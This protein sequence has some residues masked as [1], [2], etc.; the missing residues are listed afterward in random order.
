MNR[1]APALAIAVL[2]FLAFAVQAEEVTF[3]DGM[4]VR[5]RFT[6]YPLAEPL[7]AEA[8]LSQAVAGTTIPLWSASVDSLGKTFKYTMV[9]Q[10]PQIKLKNPATTIPLVIVP[11]KFVFANGDTFD[12]SAPDPTC[13]PAGTPLDLFLNS[14]LLKV[15]FESTPSDCCILGF[16]DAFLNP[17]HGH[18]FQTFAT[19]DYDTTQL[20]SPSAD[21]VD[22]SHEINE[23]QDDPSGSNPT[24]AWGHVGQVS[25]CQSNLEVGDPL[26]PPSGPVFDVKMPNGFTY[27]VQDLAFFSWFY[28][29]S[30]SIGLGGVYSLLGTF[31]TSAGPICH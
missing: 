2:A 23:L 6:Y 28:R 11:V 8:L 26:S 16:H 20:F 14:P 31:K 5:P 17:N 21:A 13:S 19:A 25:G 22:S 30:P 7:P 10:N 3:P 9:G 4:V 18:A 1:V 12:L 24:P 15:M 29:Q 27:H